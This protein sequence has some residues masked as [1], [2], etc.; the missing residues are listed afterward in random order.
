M[1]LPSAKGLFHKAIIQ[2]GPALQMA[3]REDGTRNARQFLDAL[4]IDHRRADGGP[5]G[6]D[7]GRL[8][9]HGHD[10][11]NTGRRENVATMVETI[12]RAGTK[13]M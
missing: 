12:P 11:R 4:A 3:N 6:V 13:M 7:G 9:R 8:R 1:A 5:S 10:L 2:S